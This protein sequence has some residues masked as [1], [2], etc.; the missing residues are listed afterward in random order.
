MKS[1]II[2]EKILV[3]QKN[4]SDKVNKVFLI[5][6][7]DSVYQV[8]VHYGKRGNKLKE[9]TKTPDPIS[10]YEAETIFYRLVN[11]K[12]KKGYREAVGSY[13]KHKTLEQRQAIINKLRQEATDNFYQRIITAGLNP[14]G[15]LAGTNI[16]NLDFNLEDTYE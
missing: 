4:N 8:D 12:L 15:D 5:R 7:T 3:Y 13:P 14:I 10:L 2:Q 9:I 16:S 11:S 6:A 1:Q